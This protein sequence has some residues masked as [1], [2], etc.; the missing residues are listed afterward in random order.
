MNEMVRAVMLAIHDAQFWNKSPEE[1]AR[2]A[3]EAMQK[4]M[5]NE[6]LK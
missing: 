2:L 4:A 3:I 5:I 6:A 1:V